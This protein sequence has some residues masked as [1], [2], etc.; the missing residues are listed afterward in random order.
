MATDRRSPPEARPGRSRD[1]QT[2]AETGAA[3]PRRLLDKAPV[4]PGDLEE[5]SPTGSD[6]DAQ[7][8]HERDQSTGGDST[9]GMGTGAA[10]EQQHAVMGQAHEDLQRGQV[11]TDLRAT[12]GLD[13]E[14][15]DR[16]LKEAGATAGTTTSGSD[17]GGTRRPGKRPDDKR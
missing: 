4:A 13:A 6:H 10:G 3:A 17:E 2:R 1:D 5:P 9:G 12:P 8:P 14:R 16:V 11:D 7:L 15:R